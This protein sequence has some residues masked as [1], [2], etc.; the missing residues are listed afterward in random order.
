VDLTFVSK[1][2]PASLGSGDVPEIPAGPGS[3]VSAI[4]ANIGGF[5]DKLNSIPLDDIASEVHQ[6]TSRI[7]ALSQSPEVTQSLHH[8]DDTLANIDHVSHEASAQIGPILA[9]LHRV[10]DEAQSA[11]AGVERLLNTNANTVRQPGTAGIGD[12]LYELSRAA[13][14]LRELADYLDRHP[15]ALLKG[16]GQSG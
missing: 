7:A 12:S 1:A 3:D 15:E 8:L 14:S 11:V 10:A 13:R 6:T 16:K 2:T 9:R 4:L 5:S